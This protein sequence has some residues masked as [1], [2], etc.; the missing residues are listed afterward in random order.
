[1]EERMGD[2]TVSIGEVKR[3]LAEIVNRVAFGHERI[4]LTFRG[5]PKAVLVSVEDYARLQAQE[6]LVEDQTWDD[7][8]GRAEALS[9]QILVERE[10][11]P[12]DLDLVIQANKKDLEKRPCSFLQV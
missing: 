2:K 5:K 11:K 10:G 4:V 9:E 8:L 6:Q 7:W 12:L 3:D 1:M